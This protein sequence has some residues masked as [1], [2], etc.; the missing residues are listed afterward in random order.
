MSLKNP[1]CKDTFIFWIGGGFFI[2]DIN[3]FY[4]L[5][6]DSLFRLRGSPDI[7]FFGTGGALSAWRRF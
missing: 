4:Y 3:F 5:L 2:K 6:S 1:I 7:W